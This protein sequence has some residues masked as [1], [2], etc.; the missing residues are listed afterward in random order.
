MTTFFTGNRFL[1]F[2]IMLTLNA[3]EIIEST[4]PLRGV[5]HPE[6][7]IFIPTRNTMVWIFRNPEANRV[8]LIGAADQ[9]HHL[10]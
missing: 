9:S 1:L 10:N 4:F 2:V 8:N 7:L 6:I 5:F 3:A